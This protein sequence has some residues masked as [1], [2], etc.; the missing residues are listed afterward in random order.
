[1]ND[2]KYKYRRVNVGDKWHI[3]VTG[4]SPD[5]LEEVELMLQALKEKHNWPIERIVLVSNDEAGK[6]MANGVGLQ[7]YNSYVKEIR[8]GR[9]RDDVHVDKWLGDTMNKLVRRQALQKAMNI[10]VNAE[11]LDYSKII[12]LSNELASFDENNVRFSVDAGVINRLGK[13]LVGRAETALSELIKNGYDADAEKVDLFFQGSDKVGGVLIIEDN[14]NGMNQYELL[15]GFM[16]ISSTDKVHNP[17]SPVFKR[18]RAGRKGIGR[19]AT[20]RLGHKLT[21]TTQ[22]EGAINSLQITIDWD[23]FIADTDLLSVENKIEVV[24]A[25]DKGKGTTL[26]IEGLRESWSL[27]AIK[28][29]Y[30]FIA[31]LLQP[32]P[33]SKKKAD[34]VVDSSFKVNVYK[35]DPLGYKE[36]ILNEQKAIYNQSLA[37]IE[38]H[39]N[40]SGA[41]YWTLESDKL[42]IRK[43]KYDLSKRDDK[44]NVPFD[45]L[46]NVHLKA[47]YFIYDASLFPPSTMSSIQE[48]MR[49]QGGIR[50]YRNGFRV[51]PYGEQDDDWTGLDASVRRRV[52]L[53]PHANN[54]FLGLVQITDQGGEQFDET[55]SREKLIENDAFRELSDFT[56]RAL[57]GAVLRVASIRD[58]KGTANEKR[59]PRTRKPSQAIADAAS[60]GMDAVHELVNA[61]AVSSNANSESSNT[62]TSEIDMPNATSNSNTASS[63]I[64]L[65]TA[66]ETIVEANREQEVD[67]EEKEQ[68]TKVLIDEINQLRVLAGLG[69]VIGQFVHEIKTYVT[70]FNLNLEAL[71]RLLT[72]NPEAVEILE[73]L[74]RN[75]ESFS[76]YRSYF[77]RTISDNIMRELEPIELRDVV[78]P[79]VRTISPDAESAFINLETPVFEGYNLFTIPMH[80]SEWASILFNLYSNAKKAIHRAESQGKML[81]KCGKTKSVVYLD[82][83]DNG[84]GIPPENESR[85]FDAFFTT[86][87]PSTR[88]ATFR[89]ELAGMGLGLKI[90]HDIVEGYKGRI[91]VAEPELGYVTTIRIEVPLNK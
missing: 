71:T 16:R 66:L 21:I 68:Q 1:M 62:Y 83:S 14:G 74:K 44:L 48:T 35:V 20:Q 78:R 30:R 59:S 3:E 90:V 65:K 23:K 11:N 38:G 82:F 56:Y 79:F 31:E 61:G 89:E 73:T 9:H 69:L 77:E 18:K 87:Q 4:L 54:S 34:K 46:R 64:A 45:Y 6:G 47:Y 15:N 58:R 27:A 86:S 43:Q 60:A 63:I 67:N 88:S 29:V 55:A 32:F 5:S 10:A 37:V 41:A 70:S 51:L 75:V 13:E 24:A 26:R 91:I 19:F 28:R 57:I 84:D 36:E 17:K 39:V 40:E 81:I 53:A 42:N 12:A 80:R 50:V 49:E 8:I 25:R 85:I 72:I 22:K 2:I 52:I 33:V 7:Y 76:A